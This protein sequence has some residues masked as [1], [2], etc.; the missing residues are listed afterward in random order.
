MVTIATVTVVILVTMDCV[1]GQVDDYSGLYLSTLQDSFMIC[2]FGFS[3]VY[4]KF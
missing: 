4:Y 1:R 2:V 3:D